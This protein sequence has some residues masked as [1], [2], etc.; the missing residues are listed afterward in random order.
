[1]VCIPHH[2]FRPK[3]GKEAMITAK[4]FVSLFTLCGAAALSACAEISD[5]VADE[6]VAPLYASARQNGP[7]SLDL[8]ETDVEAGLLDRDNANRYR[9]YA[10]LAPEKLPA[11]YRSNVVGKDA[12]YSMVQL[13]KDWSSLSQSSQSEILELQANGF[14]DLKSTVETAHFVLH[15]ATNGNSA[16]PAQDAGGNGIPDFIDVAAESLEAVWQREVGQLGYPAPKGTPAQ[17]FH[18]YYKNLPYYGY[19]MPTNV[20]LLATSPVAQGTASAFIVIENDFYGFP[21]NDEDVTGQEVIRGGALKVT[22]AHEFMHAV[23][24]NINVY[25]TGWLMESHATWAED[26]VYD[27][28]NDWRWY[29]DRFLATPDFPL[30]SRYLYGA[31]FF[32]NWVSE[33]RGV[34]VMRQIWFAHRTQSAPDAIRNVAFGGSWEGIAAFAPAQYLL[35][36][37][38]F[39]SD[40]GSVIPAPTNFVRARHTSYPVNVSVPAS[41]NRVPNRAP[42][43]LGSNFVEFAGTRSGSITVTFD[44]TD[45]FAWRAFAIAVPKSGGRASVIPIALNAASAGSVTVTGFGTRWARVTLAATIADRPGAEVPYTYS[46]DVR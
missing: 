41:T 19:A 17:K 40:G 38:D 33:Q 23:Q 31:A 14:G 30:F 44:G 8:I 35:D 28:I 21:P 39:T 7:T 32:Q 9:G 5:P 20:E 12:T 29:I 43:G 1:M 16:V 46:A 25:G 2:T 24:F 18:I 36:I 27:D 22:Q 11:K 42:W 6:R 15:Y 26:A 3:P 45:G 13:A 10:V 34:D 4:R 37:S